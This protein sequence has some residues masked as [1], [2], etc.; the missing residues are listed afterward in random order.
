VSRNYPDLGIRIMRLESHEYEFTDEFLR[1]L[2]RHEGG[3]L[4]SELNHNLNIE[5]DGGY[6]LDARNRLL[7]AFFHE[8]SFAEHRALYKPVGEAMLDELNML[9]VEPQ[10]DPY[11]RDVDRS[12]RERLQ[13][14]QP[15]FAGLRFFEIMIWCSLRK[16]IK[17]HM[18]LYY[19]P[20]FTEAACRNCDLHPDSFYDTSEWPN[21][22]CYFI[23]EIVSALIDW[24]TSVAHKHIRDAVPPLESSSGDHQNDSIPKSSIIALGSCLDHLVKSAVISRKYQ[25]EMLSRSV[26]MYFTLRRHP[27][28][29]EYAEVVLNVLIRRRSEKYYALLSNVL[30]GL[31]TVHFLDEHVKELRARYSKLAD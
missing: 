9:A 2:L 17:W 23:Y 18:W 1:S 21:R 24:G 26:E 30:Q 12:F 5:S 11:V 8:A 31:D 28:C 20:H 10:A 15:L 13:L 29:I 7:H 3:L 25:Y 27:D 14:R 16:G 6:R 22:Y 19:F 4:C